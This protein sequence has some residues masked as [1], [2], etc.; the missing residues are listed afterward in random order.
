M[1]RLLIRR[2]R[3]R[4]IQNLG[5]K[6]NGHSG[7]PPKTP[8][9]NPVRSQALFHFII[10]PFFPITTTLP[11]YQKEAGF[12]EQEEMRI[13]WAAGVEWMVTLQDDQYFHRPEGDYGAWRPGIP[14]DT[15]EA[16]VALMFRG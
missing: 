11:N 12:M 4:T 9:P 7:K 3:V 6:G 5:N 8:N 13:V 15:H 16:D 2:S 1:A 10:W 14:P